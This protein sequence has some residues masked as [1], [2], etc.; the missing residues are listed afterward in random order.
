MLQLEGKVGGANLE[1]KG[2][3][4]VA[5]K[6]VSVVVAPARMRSPGTFLKSKGTGGDKIRL[7]DDRNGDN[8]RSKTLEAVPS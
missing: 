6:N 8:V 3:A 5:P 1:I 7:L 4:T 2:C